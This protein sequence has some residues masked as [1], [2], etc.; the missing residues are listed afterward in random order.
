MALESKPEVAIVIPVGP[1]KELVLDTLESLEVFCPKP[2][3]VFLD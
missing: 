2:H 1:G 3:V